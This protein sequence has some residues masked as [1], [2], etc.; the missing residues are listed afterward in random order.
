M[1]LGY[2]LMPKGR[3]QRKI[4]TAYYNAKEARFII[5]L[6]DGTGDV[7]DYDW[8]VLKDGM[9][10][11]GAGPCNSFL[12]TVLGQTKSF[13]D[14]DLPDAARRIIGKIIDF[15]NEHKLSDAN[16]CLYNRIV[17][18]Y[19]VIDSLPKP[20]TKKDGYIWRDEMESGEHTE[21]CWVRRVAG[22]TE[23]LVRHCDEDGNLLDEY[24]VLAN[25]VMDKPV[26]HITLEKALQVLAEI[27]EKRR[28][29]KKQKNNNH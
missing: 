14:K 27:T 18:V 24:G 4:K 25:N 17:K 29:L 9:K 12:Q 7:G 1:K 8:R 21:G 26:L 23:L 19:G 5:E 2:S 28:A 10:D 6:E 20:S 22:G 3:Q 16:N 15:E 13:D 11:K